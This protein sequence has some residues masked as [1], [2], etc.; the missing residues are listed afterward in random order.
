MSPLR[1]TTAALVASGLL[2]TTACGDDGPPRTWAPVD[3]S[4]CATLDVGGDAAA[5]YPDL[6][7]GTPDAVSSEDSVRTT[8][9][10]ELTLGTS[11]RGRTVSLVV[12]VSSFDDGDPRSTYDHYL[13]LDLDDYGPPDESSRG[14]DQHAIDGWWDEGEHR[15]A[16]WTTSEDGGYVAVDAVL[17]DNLAAQVIVIDQG[18]SIA[19]QIDA[20][21]VGEEL[22]G[23]WLDAVQ[24]AVQDAV[25]KG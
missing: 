8:A 2:A 15:A 12:Q 6:E 11:G 7:P 21:E 24:D 23:R 18:Q 20:A 5:A 19:D 17:H 4:L 14:A 9:T 13:D 16:T 3:D 25:E 10:C 1:T 22:A